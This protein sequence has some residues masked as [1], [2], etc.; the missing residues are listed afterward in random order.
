MNK[1]ISLFSV[2]AISLTLALSTLAQS[3]DEKKNGVNNRVSKSEKVAKTTTQTPAQPPINTV[4]KS[5]TKAQSEKAMKAT[6]R[7]GG[8]SSPLKSRVTEK[9]VDQPTRCKEAKD[10]SCEKGQVKTQP[11]TKKLSH[12]DSVSRGRTSVRKIGS[13]KATPKVEAETKTE[14]AIVS[15][16]KAEQ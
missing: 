4:N 6:V 12:R 5:S 2:I 3:P 13:A 11:A 16:D 10:G 7:N 8:A 1:L 9:L 14:A 15:K